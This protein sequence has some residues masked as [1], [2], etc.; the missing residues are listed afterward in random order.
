MEKKK[1][2]KYYRVMSDQGFLGMLVNI[3]DQD[4]KAKYQ[5]KKIIKLV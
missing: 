4:R 5:K 2:K 3:I 1:K